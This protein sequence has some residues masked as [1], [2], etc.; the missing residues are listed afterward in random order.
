VGLL[1]G[2]GG[3]DG[4]GG[5]YLPVLWD[6]IALIFHEWPRSPIPTTV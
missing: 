2:N 3:G 6:G 4:G 5:L 1:G